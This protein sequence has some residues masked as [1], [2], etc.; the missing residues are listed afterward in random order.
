MYAVKPH[1]VFFIAWEIWLC[2]FFINKLILSINCQLSSKS[3]LLIFSGSIY[4]SI[5][6]DTKVIHP[7]YY[8]HYLKGANKRWSGF[9]LI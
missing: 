4:P 6:L 3:D 5:Y 2:N 1:C 8:K 7:K 9:K